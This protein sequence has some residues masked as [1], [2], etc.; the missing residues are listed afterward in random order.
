MPG[1]RSRVRI[2]AQA[3]QQPHLIPARGSGFMSGCRKRRAVMRRD[4]LC[5]IQRSD[6]KSEATPG[7]S[8]GLPFISIPAAMPQP[9]IRTSRKFANTYVFSGIKSILTGS[10]I[11][12]AFPGYKVFNYK[13]YEVLG[14]TAQT[15][16]EQLHGSEWRFEWFYEIGQ[17][18]Q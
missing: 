7:I 3:L 11:D 10:E 8:T 15:I 18:L 2:T 6:L 9:P 17:S 13:R 5:Q 14:G 4:G 12:P 16:I 1:F